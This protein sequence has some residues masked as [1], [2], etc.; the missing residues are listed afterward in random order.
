MTD[1][2]ADIREMYARLGDVK[3]PEPIKLTAEQWDW[4]KAQVELKPASGWDF[5]GLGSPLFG[6]PIRIVA[7]VEESTPHLKAWFGWRVKGDGDFPDFT[8][9]P[10]S[11]SVAPQPERIE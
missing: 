11:A 5:G 3:A 2:M 6:V 7:T 8:I 10:S 1:P 9:P 4:I